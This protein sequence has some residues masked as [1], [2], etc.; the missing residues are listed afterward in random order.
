MVFQM[1]NDIFIS[2]IFHAYVQF[3]LNTFK[4]SFEYVFVVQ[5][6]FSKSIIKDLST[7]IIEYICQ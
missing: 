6:Q 2:D 3:R 7:V 1:F 4:Y 5:S